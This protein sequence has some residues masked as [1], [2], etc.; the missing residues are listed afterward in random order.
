M[1]SSLDSNCSARPSFITAI[2]YLGAIIRSFE[3]FIVAS[4]MTFN[5]GAN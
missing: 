4:E 1:N 5:E 3:A 2:E